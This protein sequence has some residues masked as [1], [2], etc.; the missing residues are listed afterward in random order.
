VSGDKNYSPWLVSFVFLGARRNLFPKARGSPV[1]H[2]DTD[3]QKAD[4]N[5]AGDSEQCGKDTKHP[6][7]YVDRE[8]VVKTNYT[9]AA[10]SC[11]AI[12]LCCAGEL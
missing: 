8:G 12:P 7:E 3:E 2:S 9:S 5:S 6:E 4:L 1:R 11:P 10:L